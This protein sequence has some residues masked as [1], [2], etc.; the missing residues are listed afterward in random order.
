[1]FVTDQDH[2]DTLTI[3]EEFQSEPKKVVKKLISQ[4]T[5]QFMLYTEELKHDPWILFRAMDL[6]M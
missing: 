5:L 6:S 3:A 2:L 4:K 1:M